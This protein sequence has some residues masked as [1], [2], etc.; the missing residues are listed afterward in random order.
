M[1]CEE[2]WKGR[3][4]VYLYAAIYG[5]MGLG[6][7]YAAK[8]YAPIQPEIQGMAAGIQGMEAGMRC[9]VMAQGM[10]EMLHAMED[11]M[12]EILEI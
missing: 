12:A 1:D 6:M 3:G 8:V 4:M 7:V 5:V 11:G 2:S 10:P 9:G